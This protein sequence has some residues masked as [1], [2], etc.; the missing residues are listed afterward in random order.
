[1]TRH[2]FKT[3]V[4]PFI[5]ALGLF[6]LLFLL[7]DLFVNIWAYMNND[8]PLE[9]IAWSLLLYLPKCLSFSLPISLLFGS[10]F[11]LGTLY[12]Q[13]ELIIVFG[14]GRSLLRFVTPLILIGLIASSFS[15][16]FDEYVVLPTYQAKKAY[17]KEILRQA[18][19][20]SMGRNTIRSAGGLTIYHSERFD[21]STSTLFMPSVVLR[22]A[23]GKVIERVDAA[24]AR[25]S[26]DHW[27]FLQARRFRWL[28]DGSA[29]T[30]ENVSEYDGVGYVEPPE[31]FVR[32]VVDVAEFALSQLAFQ[33]NARREAG[34]P[35]IELE[36]E[37]WGRWFFALTPFVVIVLST[38]I[39][40]RF[41]KNVMLMCLLLSLMV[42][43]AYFILKMVTVVLAN[44]GYISPFMAALLP[45]GSFVAIATA[46]FM[47]ART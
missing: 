7:L 12:S 10:S 30:E 6:S 11:A 15:F 26:G 13:N 41:R 37:Y 3:F 24:S 4:N 23:T 32:K 17:V 42:A 39:G 1:M 16:A 47:I 9:K 31:S 38:S 2:L 19:P 45:V 28:D 36:T 33:I 21:A 35:Y 8:V 27:V 22:D 40:G 29:M 20:Q 34:Q 18:D 46:L 5:V 43:S 14:S 44:Q 25:W